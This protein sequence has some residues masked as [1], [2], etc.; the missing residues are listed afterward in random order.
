MQAMGSP[1]LQPDRAG[2]AFRDHFATSSETLESV[3]GAVEDFLRAGLSNSEIGQSLQV[4]N[5]PMHYAFQFS[6]R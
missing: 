5:V 4:R 3:R 2:L 1:V 6:D